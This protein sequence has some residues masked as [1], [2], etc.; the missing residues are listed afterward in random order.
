MD[1]KAAGSGLPT[2]VMDWSAEKAEVISRTAQDGVY[3]IPYMIFP[4]SQR[5]LHFADS[6]CLA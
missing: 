4:W 2:E 5:T 6:P 1:P 3:L